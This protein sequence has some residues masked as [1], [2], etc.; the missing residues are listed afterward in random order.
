MEGLENI[1]LDYGKIAMGV[2]AEF[3]NLIFR[4]K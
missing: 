1:K 2:G 4:H 3:E